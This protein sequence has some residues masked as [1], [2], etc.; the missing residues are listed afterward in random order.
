MRQ[1]FILQLGVP[2]LEGRTG[3]G[4]AGYDEDFGHRVS[5]GFRASAEL[6]F[7]ESRGT[8]ARG[9]KTSYRPRGGR[10]SAPV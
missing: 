2:E 3:G 4:R 1:L 8:P 6:K 5:P 9:A 10:Q 7:R